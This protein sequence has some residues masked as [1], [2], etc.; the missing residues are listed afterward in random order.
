[1]FSCFSICLVA[2]PTLIPFPTSNTHIITIFSFWL[3]RNPCSRVQ[4]RANSLESVRQDRGWRKALYKLKSWTSTYADDFWVLVIWIIF[5]GLSC[6]LSGDLKKKKKK[7]SLSCLGELTHCS[8]E[9]GQAFKI[10]Y[11]SFILLFKIFEVLWP[12]HS[13]YKLISLEYKFWKS[14]IILSVNKK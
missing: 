5:S 4:S 14:Q 6:A 1:M 3:S 11:L 7:S 9:Y 13:S 10:I 2:A 12:I 8:L